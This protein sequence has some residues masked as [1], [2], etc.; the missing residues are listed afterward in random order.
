MKDWVDKLYFID[1]EIK[2][3]AY[4]KFEHANAAFR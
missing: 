1:D 4:E 3:P 2:K